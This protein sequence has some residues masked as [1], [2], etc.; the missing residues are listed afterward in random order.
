M[1][2]KQKVTLYLP[3]ELHRKLKIQAAMSS[4]AMSILAER[5]LN[6]YLMYPEVVE[7]QDEAHGQTHRIYDCPSCTTPV[8]LRNGELTALGQ[9]GSVL[10]DELSTVTIGSPSEEKVVVPC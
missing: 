8:V 3:P 4:E 9:H 6:F 2:D 10:Q 7:Q 5:A 1:Q